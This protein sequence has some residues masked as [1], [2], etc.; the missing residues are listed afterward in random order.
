MVRG[1]SVGLV[2]IPENHGWREGS[3]RGWIPQRESGC[4]GGG[5]GTRGREG[6]GAEPLCDVGVSLNACNCPTGSVVQN[7]SQS[8]EGLSG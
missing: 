8:S 2:P 4:F 6:A 7:R 3:L 1:K 5:A